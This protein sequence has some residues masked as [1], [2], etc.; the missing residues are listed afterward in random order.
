MHDA[1]Q[2]AGA[3]H[4]EELEVEHRNEVLDDIDPAKIPANDTASAYSRRML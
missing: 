3:P 1:A 4:L 2:G